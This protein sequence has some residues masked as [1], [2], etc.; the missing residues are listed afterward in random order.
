MSVQVL[1]NRNLSL[2][3][4]SG[5]SETVVLGGT[6]DAEYPSIIAGG[7]SLAGAYISRVSYGCKPGSYILLKNESNELIGVYDSTGMI[8]YIG[9]GLPMPTMGI[10]R[11]SSTDAN[12]YIL[13][14]LRKIAGVFDAPAPY[15]PE[16][17]AYFAA[18]SVQPDDVLKNHLNDFILALKAGSVWDALDVAVLPLHDA[19]ASRVNMIHPAMVA[20]A[21]NAPTF[22]AYRGWT[23]DGATSYVRFADYAPLDAGSWHYTLNDASLFAWFGARTIANYNY[24]AGFGGYSR[25]RG[26]ASSA[27]I[28]SSGAVI[29]SPALPNA[30]R[31]LGGCRADSS[32]VRVY[33]NGSLRGSAALVSTSL[34]VD[35][36]T[37]PFKGAPVAHPVRAV[38][39]GGNLTDAQVAALYAA[40]SAYLT[41][42]G[43]V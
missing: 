13:V 43:A 41:A 6:S 38:F 15:D 5:I 21:V 39:A 19:Q 12:A 10:L 36:L 7:E 23:S 20:T 26:H 14:E 18:M 24:E 32:T 9:N 29:S 37:F 27:E 42:I 28:N 31:F 1:S 30:E 22:T 17:A 34:N 3:Q 40:T 11:Y 2:I 33:G 35:E 16:A 25:I 8:D 4:I